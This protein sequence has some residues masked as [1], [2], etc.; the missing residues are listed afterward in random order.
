MAK[1]SCAGFHGL[2]SNREE[3]AEG[4]RLFIPRRAENWQKYQSRAESVGTLESECRF[5]EPFQERASLIVEEKP[6]SI[7]E[8]AV[9][10]PTKGVWPLSELQQSVRDRWW[11]P[12]FLAVK[13]NLRKTDARETTGYAHCDRLKEL[14]EC[15]A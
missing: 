1:T 5:A 11:M 13:R 10:I 8:R 15:Q 14:D 2:S 7:P 6:Q 12:L 4:I 9:R 3:L